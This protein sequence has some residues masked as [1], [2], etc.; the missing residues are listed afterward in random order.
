MS[1]PQLP[2]EIIDI[3]L[4]MEREMKKKL[5]HEMTVEIID[6]ASE[7]WEDWND[8]TDDEEWLGDYLDCEMCCDCYGDCVQDDRHRCD[9]V[10]HEFENQLDKRIHNNY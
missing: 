7:Y 2:Q 8:R 10:Y 6:G 9:C 3:I 4:K 1:V 5:S